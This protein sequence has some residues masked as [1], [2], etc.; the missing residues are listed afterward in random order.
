MYD[1][2]QLLVDGPRGIVRHLAGL[3]FLYSGDPYSQFQVSYWAGRKVIGWGIY[4][5]HKIALKHLYAVERGGVASAASFGE[6]EAATVDTGF[7]FAVPNRAA[8]LLTAHSGKAS[9]AAFA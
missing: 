5:A 9:R 4:E 7:G 2:A 6:S 3:P 8:E 1:I